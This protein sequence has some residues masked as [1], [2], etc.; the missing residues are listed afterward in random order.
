MRKGHEVCGLFECV[1]RCTAKRDLR[2]KWAWSITMQDVSLLFLYPC[3]PHSLESTRMP[4]ATG[5][6]F[7]TDIS[8]LESIKQPVVTYYAI[9][10][11][12]V[13]SR[14]HFLISLSLPRA[15]HRSHSLSLRPNFEEY[16]YTR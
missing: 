13:C 3:G 4:S 11:H 5:L 16:L 8:V 12:I 9:L 2:A 7:F 15:K 14:T 10:M 1:L 6:C